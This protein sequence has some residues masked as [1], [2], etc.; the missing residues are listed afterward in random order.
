MN[1]GL[2]RVFL[3]RGN[4]R[5]FQKGIGGIIANTFYQNAKNTSASTMAKRVT[6]TT[7]TSGTM[8]E[9]VSE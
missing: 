3:R 7:S 1:E 5:I 4:G 9:K 2:L 6:I 8:D